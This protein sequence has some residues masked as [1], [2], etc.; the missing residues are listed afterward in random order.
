[1]DLTA[2][3]ISICKGFPLDKTLG[4]LLH[5]L[6]NKETEVMRNISDFQCETLSA[7][8]THEK[9]SRNRCQ[10]YQCCN[11]IAHRPLHGLGG[12]ME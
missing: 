1:M 12:H 4:C 11:Y 9:S 8:V 7:Y 2:S 3:S 6:R 5:S 10:L